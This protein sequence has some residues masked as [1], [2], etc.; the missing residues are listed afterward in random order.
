MSRAVTTTEVAISA[1][2]DGA[3]GTYCGASDAMTAGTVTAAPAVE[4][5]ATPAVPLPLPSRMSASTSMVPVIA[6]TDRPSRMPSTP[7][8]RMTVKLRPLPSAKAKNGTITLTPW[9]KK[10]RR[11]LSR[12]PSAK[13]IT[14]GS[15]AP[16]RLCHGKAASPVR[17]ERAHRHERTGFERHQ[18]EGAGFL[19]GAELL[20]QRHVEAAVGV[21]HRRHDGEHR[22]PGEE[23][24]VD[25]AR[26][27]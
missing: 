20:H 25:A 21:V 2:A 24:A 23:A 18:A 19:L 1:V 5:A 11:S 26:S 7:V 17:P 9:L 12:L 16:T 15:S 13:P 10:A 6:I 4:P 22:K 14:N 8:F 3:I 27:E